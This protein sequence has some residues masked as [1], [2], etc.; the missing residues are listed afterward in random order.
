V[1]LGR[2]GD[3]TATELNKQIE[4]YIP[5]IYDLVELG[6]LQPS[7]YEIIGKVGVD[8]V[9]DVYAYQQAGKGGNKKVIVQIAEE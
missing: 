8:S 1:R 3:P 5:V 9:P 7:E 4:S 2:I 6:K